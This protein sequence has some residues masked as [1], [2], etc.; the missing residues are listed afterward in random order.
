MTEMLRALSESGM[1]IGAC[2]VAPAAMA[3][4]VGLVEDKT[5][6]STVAKDLFNELF[7][8]GGDPKTLV[9]E[10]GLAQ[11]SDSGAIDGLADQAIEA[12]PKSVADYRAGKGAALQFLVGQV[13][14]LSKGKANPQMA[15]EALKRLLG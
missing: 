10:R 2:R 3:G 5:I 1:E 15:A 9:E 8:K 12:N 7:E 6:N 14:R 4:L 13:M 11:V